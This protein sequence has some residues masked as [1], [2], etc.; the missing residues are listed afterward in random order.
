MRPGECGFPRILQA[1]EKVAA[2]PIDGLEPGQKV[3]KTG[4]SVPE[5]GSKEHEGVFQQAR[6]FSETRL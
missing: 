4:L 6:V 3:Q 1:V 5:Q 2:G